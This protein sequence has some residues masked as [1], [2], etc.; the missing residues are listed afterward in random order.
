[1]KVLASYYQQF[2]ADPAQEVP[3]ESYTGWQRAEIEIGPA[4]LVVIYVHAFAAFDHD[5]AGALVHDGIGIR[6]QLVLHIAQLGVVQ[7]GH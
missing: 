5:G 7:C 4:A 3:G 1:M 6:V 2:D